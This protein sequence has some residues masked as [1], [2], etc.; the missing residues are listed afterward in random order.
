MF[1]QRRSIANSVECF[2]RRLFVCLHVC[3]C[4]YNKFQMTKHKVMK[5]G[6]RCI[7]QKSW[8]SSNLDIDTWVRTPEN[9]ALGYDIGKISA[10]CLGVMSNLMELA[11]SRLLYS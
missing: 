7:I 4:E 9:V 3:V 10:G 11:V 6:G 2:Q 8:Q 5:I 1:T